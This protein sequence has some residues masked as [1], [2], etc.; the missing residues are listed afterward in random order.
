MNKLTLYELVMKLL[1]EE[2]TQAT[3]LDDFD[4]IG[5]ILGGFINLR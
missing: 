4:S 5:R 1:D 2:N 3:I